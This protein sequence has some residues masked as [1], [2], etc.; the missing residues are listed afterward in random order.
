[1]KPAILCLL[2]LPGLSGCAPHL[3]A[4]APPAHGQMPAEFPAAYYRQAEAAGRQ[5][6][7]I[8]AGRSLVSVEVHRGGPLAALGH[9]HVVAGRDLEGQV[10]IDG[11]RADLYLA[12]DR[13]SVDEP[14]LRT[15]AGLTT[16]PSREDIE[17]TRR[18]MLVK[19][20]AA[21]RHPFALIRVSRAGANAHTL[22]V[23]ITLNG[24][25][26]AYEVPAHLETQPAGILV[27][28]RM[29]LN[30]SDFGIMPFAILGGALQVQDR[31]DL[32][33]RILAGEV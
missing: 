21:E 16:Q 33:F 32:R 22:R 4:P 18:N 8:D 26:H 14:G 5:V 28:G 30:Q 7:R 10:D 19:V 6:L 17:G 20:L 15:Q 31:V 3:P 2:V 11:G 1:M 13:L 9:D 25:E 29:S 24:R 12:L 23:A 27:S